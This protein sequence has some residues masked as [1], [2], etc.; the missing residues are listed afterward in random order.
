MM[1]LTQN[2][3][4]RKDISNFY[5]QQ[6]KIKPYLRGKDLIKIGVKPGPEFTKILNQ[7]LDAKLDGNLKTKKDEVFF[8]TQIAKKN[9]LID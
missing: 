2:D 7:I 9:K 6:R 4:I 8:A 1:A 5:T 3:A